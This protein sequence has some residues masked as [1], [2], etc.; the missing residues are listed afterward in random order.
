[1]KVFLTV[2]ATLLAAT[3]ARAQ[4]RIALAAL[5]EEATAAHP[6]LAAAEQQAAAAD[7]RIVQAR[8]L[9][10]PMISAGYTS[11]GRPW[12]GAGLGV[13][14]N[15]N[16]GVMV[17]QALPFPGKRALAGRIAA[18]EADAERQQIDAVRL[19]VVS[20]VKQAYFGLAYTYAV[21]D[22]LARNQA[23]LAT[24]LEVSE[25]RYAV[26]YAAQQDVIKAQTELSILALRQERVRQERTAREG[27]LN[28]LLN[29]TPGHPVGR[30][31]D[32]VLVP[33]EH[34]LPVLLD[35]AIAHAPTLQ[36]D[37]IRVEGAQLAVDAARTDYRPDFAIA[38]GYASMGSMP[39]MYEARFD[40][41]LPL[42]RGRR[43]AAVAEN[44]GMLA[45]ARH[46]YD[47]NRLDI[48]SQL[49]RDFATASASL[50]LA[51]LYVSTVLPQSRLALESSMV[52]YQT[53]GVDFLSVLTSF[54]SVL[55][56]EMT[57]FEELVQFHDAVSRIEEVIG[58]PLVH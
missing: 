8:S 56:Y 28:A 44:V 31:E 22:V 3:P 14:P 16:I 9:P 23:L 6:R 41:T 27:E 54:A 48:Q 26:G 15:A 20:R 34:E 32:L 51:R 57:Y 21:D 53:G 30:P 29:R 25:G 37:R 1:M 33:F 4:D 47:A 38:G 42:Q 46:E 18:R 50:R 17:S 55:D 52:S 40:V 39:P 24:L 19:A 43:A 12:P 13:E 5:V 10:D 35:L 11:I 45:A 49:Q 7:A 2:L 36:R 58:S